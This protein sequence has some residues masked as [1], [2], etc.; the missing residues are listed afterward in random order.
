MADRASTHRVLANES[1][2]TR[3]LLDWFSC[4]KRDL[5]WR[6][7]YSPYQVWI[8]EIMLQ[9][10]QMDRGVTYFK[11]WMER[12]PDVNA[13]ALAQE[14]DVLKHWE[15]LG[16]Y[17]RARNLH[18]AAQIIC[19]DH[20]G[21]LPATVHELQSLPG[22]GPY[23]AKA[24][25]SIA[26]E[27]DVCVID[28]N[29]ERVM[30]RLFAITA[31]V[32][33][34]STQKEIETLCLRLLPNGEARPFNQALME[35]GSLVCTPRNPKCPTCPVAEWCIGYFQGIQDTLPIIPKPLPTIHI[36][37]ASGILIQNGRVFIQ[38]RLDSDIW[39]NLWEFPGGVVETGETPEETVIREYMEETGLQV[40]DPTHIA[41]FKHSY[42]RYRVT[43]TAFFVTLRSSPAPVMLTAAQEY[44][45]SSWSEIN[46]LAFPAGHRKLVEHL[47]GSSSFMT[48]VN[49]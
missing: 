33:T 30:S 28:A 8:S 37:M 36:A 27:Q 35:F 29:V 21:C 46:T 23:T 19:A 16:Y 47:N 2:L 20:R 45:W 3:T 14:E 17:S 13:L 1:G 7:S 24:I 42:T 43:L 34:R 26:F 10:T 22:I 4:F 9:Q 11:R 12:F 41:T 18:K 5:P 31:P 38:K 40:I 25:A 49:P 39:A 15:G 48:Q 44:R 32:K 6:Q